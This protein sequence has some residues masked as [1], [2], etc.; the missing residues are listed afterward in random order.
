[1]PLLKKTELFLHHTFLGYDIVS[2]RVKLKGLFYHCSWNKLQNLAPSDSFTF[3]ILAV[4]MNHI[5]SN[6]PFHSMDGRVRGDI[7]GSKGKFSGNKLLQQL[8]LESEI[9]LVNLKPLCR[10]VFCSRSQIHDF[11]LNSCGMKTVF[12]I[13]RSHYDS[14]NDRRRR[15]FWSSFVQCVDRTAGTPNGPRCMPGHAELNH[16]AW[17]DHQTTRTSQHHAHSQELGLDDTWPLHQLSM[18]RMFSKMEQ[19]M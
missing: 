12:N 17:T 4:K 16:P 7:F 13:G 19:H 10:S 1:M 2:V 6:I 5:R 18:Q 15:E 11:S 8:I 9:N 3:V 14:F